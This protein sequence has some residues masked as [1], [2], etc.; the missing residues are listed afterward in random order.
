MSDPALALKNAIYFLLM[1]IFP[2]HACIFLFKKIMIQ[3]AIETFEFATLPYEDLF[4]TWNAI[5]QKEGVLE[6]HECLR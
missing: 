6:K 5:G 4:L 3:T 1:Q 2:D